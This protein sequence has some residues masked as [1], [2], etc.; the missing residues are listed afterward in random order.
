[1]ARERVQE[2]SGV[3]EGGK[4]RVRKERKRGRGKNRKVGRKGN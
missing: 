4:A 1:M 3:E 2:T